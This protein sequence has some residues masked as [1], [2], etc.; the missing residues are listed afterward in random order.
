MGW[1]LA[2]RYDA[3]FI[4]KANYGNL[5]SRDGAVVMNVPTSV[6][7]TGLIPGLGWSPGVENDNPLQFS[8]LEN[9]M[10]RGVWQATVHKVAKSKTRQSAHACTH[11]HTHTHTHRSRQRV[12]S[13][14]RWGEWS[15]GSTSPS[16]EA[17]V[18]IKTA[19]ELPCG[20]V[21]RTWTQSPASCCYTQLDM[22]AWKSHWKLP[23]LLSS[24]E[25]WD[26]SSLPE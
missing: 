24:S 3:F 22:W 9:P 6:G 1:E 12:W 14:W 11:T 5:W 19:I 25:K 10:D 15:S 4:V 20:W 21:H 13:D 17:E 23:C 26:N 7:G 2:G 16:E 8:C 18:L